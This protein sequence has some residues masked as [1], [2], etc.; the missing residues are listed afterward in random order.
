MGHRMIAPKIVEGYQPTAEDVTDAVVRF[1][2]KGGLIKQLPEEKTPSRL[3][4]STKR[5]P[6]YEKF[7]VSELYSIE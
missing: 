7:D 3:L 5:G 4:I 1:K 2:E 6:A